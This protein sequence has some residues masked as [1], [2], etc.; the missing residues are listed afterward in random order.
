MAIFGDGA[1][2]DDALLFEVDETGAQEMV[3]SIN[4][5]HR[6][7]IRFT[8]VSSRPVNVWWRDFEGHRRFYVLLKPGEFCDINTFAT[9][10]WEFTDQATGERYYIGENVIFRAPKIRGDVRYR[11]NW[12]IS[13]GLRSLRDAALMQV[14]LSVPDVEK[15]ANLGLPR[16]ISDDLRQLVQILTRPRQ[17]QPGLEWRLAYII[18]AD[19]VFRVITGNIIS[20]VLTYSA[21]VAV[22]YAL[23]Y[24]G[25]FKREEWEYGPTR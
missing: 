25:W 19:K 6:V 18:W 10:P 1:R 21:A 9:H 22:R 16:V 17:L 2:D 13:V 5:D 3:R 24:I 20:C 15:V 23:D 7:Y 11:T 4:S 14:A 12:N 8:N